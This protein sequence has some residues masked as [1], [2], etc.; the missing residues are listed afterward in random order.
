M[1]GDLLTTLSDAGHVAMA[2]RPDN[3]VFGAAFDAEDLR[4]L[5]D[6]IMTQTTG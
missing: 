5:V 2:V 4:S 3:Y 1:N 6:Q